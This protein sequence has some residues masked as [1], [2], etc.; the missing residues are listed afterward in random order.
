MAAVSSYALDPAVVAGILVVLVSTNPCVR[1][2]AQAASLM[3]LRWDQR[4]IRNDIGWHSL[5]DP[6]STLGWSEVRL[7]MV[8]RGMLRCGEKPDA[9]LN[10]SE[11]GA[12]SGSVSNAPTGV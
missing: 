9:S 10:Q 12:E 8:L 1:R 11:I 3:L 7:A 2:R 6:E 4:D 5:L